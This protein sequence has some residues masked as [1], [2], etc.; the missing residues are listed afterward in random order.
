MR[1]TWFG[2]MAIGRTED[3]AA[4]RAATRDVEYSRANA[5]VGTPASIAADMRAFI[6]VGCSY[7]M[8]D[9][10]GLPDEDVIRLV[11]DELLPEVLS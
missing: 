6:D 2:R 7:F 9:I 5:F 1:A 8:L 11:M 3:E 4:T 10:I